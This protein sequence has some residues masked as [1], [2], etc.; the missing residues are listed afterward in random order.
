M[1][2]TQDSHF[3]SSHSSFV[4]QSLRPGVP[5]S[6]ATGHEEVSDGTFP[7]MAF[8]W[9]MTYFLYFPFISSSFRVKDH[10]LTVCCNHKKKYIQ[11][12]NFITI[13]IRL[14]CSLL[15]P[16]YNFNRLL[17]Q[18]PYSQLQPLPKPLAT[19]ASW[20]DILIIMC[21]DYYNDNLFLYRHCYQ[22]CKYIILFNE[23]K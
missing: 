11:V 16:L 5:H 20:K 10:F 13:N 1:V 15:K 2:T 9:T 4:M 21:H 3:T 7:Q 14:K 23:Q 18:I 8:Y 12:Y 17:Y 6:E 19:S 22:H